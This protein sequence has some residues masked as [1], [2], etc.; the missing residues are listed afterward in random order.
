MKALARLILV[1]MVLSSAANAAESADSKSLRVIA[2]FDE[3]IQNSLGGYF[4]KFES[5]PSSASAFATE[6]TFRGGAGRSLKIEAHQ[7]PG[8]FCGAWMHLFD[9][10]ADQKKF[11]DSRNFAYLSFWV[12]GEKGGEDFTIKMADET[13][14]GKE[15]SVP[16]GSVKQF[17]PGGITTQ[18]QEVLVPLAKLDRLDRMSMGGVTFDFTN[19][20]DATVYIDDISFKTTPKIATPETRK[21]DLAAAAGG[22]PLPRAMWVWNTEPVLLDPAYRE[23]MFELCKQEN[24]DLLWV[25]IH[26]DYEPKTEIYAENKPPPA[27]LRC[28]LKN[29]D[30]LREFLKEAHA[31]GLKV[32]ALD[33]FPEYAEKPYHH[34]PLAAVDAVI[35]FNKESKPEER[36]DGI[37]F[38]NEPYLIIGW[39]DWKIREEILKEYLDLNAEI[40][41]RCRANG[42]SYG[43]DI[44]FWW[45]EKDE[46]T[47]K[48]S[49]LVTYNGVEKPASYHCI[50]LLDNVGIMNYRD[51]ADGAD[52][53][54]AHG[55][56]LLKYADAAKKA[57]V[58]MGVET[59]TYQPTT[60]WFAV[61]L[62]RAAFEAAL[63][64]KAADFASRSRINGFRTQIFDDG[65]N[66]HVGIE[67]APKPTPEQ[68]KKAIETL[69]EIAKRFGAS[70]DPALKDKADPI[71]M[72]AEFAVSSDVE[73]D[74]AKA[75]NIKNPAGPEFAGFTAVSIMLGKITFAD[76]D[77]GHLQTQ[78]KAAEKAFGKHP[79]FAGFAIHYYDTYLEKV[80]QSKKAPAK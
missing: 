25:Q 26:C 39:R 36:Y 28:V 1:L 27:G 73:W 38:D 69:V 3:G 12:R 15:D 55:Q 40:Q 75:K 79:S 54:I 46:K 35:A 42:L 18:W 80:E 16:V 8:G 76:E 49:G 30:K 53:I 4:N 44:P 77:Y 62:P 60:V 63:R 58:Y 5:A 29:T 13:W 6:E 9:M 2:T 66:L 70:A 67:L 11:F 22:K 24:I 14:I 10:K 59:F 45:Q 47:G 78:L 23:K 56:D 48:V 33:G 50:D 34:V 31:A 71:R 64:S 52:G 61:G 17:L 57:K 37:H 51:A 21:G 72:D 65:A 20:G 7:K 74:N 19:P 43:V 68:E 32:H 41:K